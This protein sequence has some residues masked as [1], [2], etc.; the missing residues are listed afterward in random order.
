MIAG[1]ERKKGEL[2]MILPFVL[3]LM[4][5][6]L[7]SHFLPLAGHDRFHEG[8]VTFQHNNTPCSMRFRSVSWSL[9]N[10]VS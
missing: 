9:T 8:C 3:F 4:I 5:D 7:S 6:P 10:E 2:S 1:F